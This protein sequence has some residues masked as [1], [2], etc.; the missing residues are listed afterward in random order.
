MG[1]KTPVSIIWIH[2]SAPSHSFRPRWSSAAGSASVSPWR[3]RSAAGGNL[4]DRR[5]GMPNPLGFNRLD[6]NTFFG[7][8][9]P[10]YRLK[11][12]KYFQTKITFSFADFQKMSLVAL[13]ELY[14]KLS[15][16]I[17]SQSWENSRC[18]WWRQMARRYP[19]ICDRALLILETQNPM[20]RNFWELSID[21]SLFF[22][23]N[24]PKTALKQRNVPV[25]WRQT[26]TN[27]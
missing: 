5:S 26:I 27:W 16:P 1:V 20:Q 2:P 18:P 15:S 23:K 7:H 22:K 13:D 12:S 11:E 9:R 8:R 24:P 17:W 4:T 14:R 19:S 21:S 10:F 3:I 25:L 6:S